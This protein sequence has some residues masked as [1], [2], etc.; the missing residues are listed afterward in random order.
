MSSLRNV[1]KLKRRKAVEEF[2]DGV[3]SKITVEYDEHCNTKTEDCH[4]DELDR[5]H[6]GY[7]I[8]HDNDGDADNDFSEQGKLIEQAMQGSG[9]IECD[10]KSNTIPSIIEYPANDDHRTDQAEFL[11]QAIEKS[12]MNRNGVLSSSSPVAIGTTLFHRFHK[13]RIQIQQT[14]LTILS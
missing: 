8:D 6:P 13:Y 2:F 10:K 4:E 3:K 11:R 14:R 7:H 12:K 5:V 9:Q 1:I